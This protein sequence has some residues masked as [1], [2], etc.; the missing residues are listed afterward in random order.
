MTE[1]YATYLDFSLMEWTV[2]LVC[3]CLLACAVFFGLYFNQAGNQK[4]DDEHCLE[5]IVR[6]GFTP[7]NDQDGWHLKGYPI[8]CTDP[9]DLLCYALV[10]EAAPKGQGEQPK[11]PYQKPELKVKVDVTPGTAL[12]NGFTQAIKPLS[13]HTKGEDDVS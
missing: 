5:L 4:K 2:I 13:L 6:K 10:L 3:A 9:V 1:F 12:A 8:R 11:R 7:V